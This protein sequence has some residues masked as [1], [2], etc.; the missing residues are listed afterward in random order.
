MKGSGLAMWLFFSL[1]VVVVV[2]VDMTGGNGGV[3]S[4]GG[5]GVGVRI[6]DWNR[7]VDSELD[8]ESESGPGALKDTFEKENGKSYF[9]LISMRYKIGSKKMGRQKDK[10]E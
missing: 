7:G 2:E 6:G 3:G 4:L 9:E 1:G 10:S 8:L 5:D